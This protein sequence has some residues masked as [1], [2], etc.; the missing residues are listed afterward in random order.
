[1]HQ[2]EVTA[3][4]QAW[5]GGDQGALEKLVPLVYAELRRRARAHMRRE[6]ASNTLEATEL[7]HE[8]FERL[9]RARQVDW[10]DRTHFFAVWA[11]LMRRVL[12]DHARSRGYLKRG[13]GLTFVPIGDSAEVPHDTVEVLALDEALTRLAAFD[14]RKVEII[15]MR[16]FAGMTA[17]ETAE[18]LGTSLESIKWEWRMARAWLLRELDPERARGG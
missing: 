8:T 1:M 11:R 17:Q 7:V 13:G 4:L 12:V 16:F 14:P 2:G 15:E 18:A 5:R 10:R 6:Q 3:L 9:V